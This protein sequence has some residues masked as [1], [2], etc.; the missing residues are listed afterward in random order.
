VQ[1]NAQACGDVA[2]TNGMLTGEILTEIGE[3]IEQVQVMVEGASGV[4]LWQADNVSGT[5]QVEVTAGVEAT[6]RPVKNTD[7][8]NGVS[9]SDLVVIQKEILGK[10]TLDTWYKQKAAD[11]NDDGKVS[12][13]DLI[14]LR[15]L[16]LGKIDQLPSSNSWRF[17]EKETNKTA[18]HIDQM[19][20]QM[21]ID[22]VGVKIGDV[23]G[24]TN[25]ALKSGRSNKALNLMTTR[26]LV[27]D[28]ITIRASDDYETSG[29]QFTLEFDV[30]KLQISSVL[31]GIGFDVSQENFNL[32][33]QKAGWITISWN[34]R[35]GE[36]LNL[37]KG[38]EL[39]SFKVNAGN[40]QLDLSEI[41]TISSKIT[42]AEAYVENDEVANV[43][44]QFEAST[45]E[46][47]FT[48]D[49][50]RPNPWKHSTVIGFNLP[51]ATHANL[52]IFDVNGRLIKQYNA[53]STKGYNEWQ[54]NSAD[55]PATGVYY[56]KLET[57]GQTAIRKMVLMN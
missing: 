12:A 4:A 38:Q 6:V 17:Y 36:L 35:D 29:F 42:P 34:A 56:Y 16:I 41:M 49:Q 39:F 33:H 13:I 46:E 22:F 25:P 19:L 44:L 20:E 14:E 8:V 43:S 24:S 3:K 23:N 55:V 27:D 9:T 57:N 30:S 52:S 26:S 37:E 28:M 51:E 31:P 45:I 32:D 48:L 5:Y 7:P 54:V 47:A 18:Y 40:D 21:N 50:N 10:A 1:N 11:S 15:K 2:R 53:F